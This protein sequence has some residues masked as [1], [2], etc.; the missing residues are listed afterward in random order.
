LMPR[1]VARPPTIAAALLAFLPPAPL[2]AARFALAAATWVRRVWGGWS[3][4][5]PGF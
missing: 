2:A 3:G 4:R 1:Y 5:A